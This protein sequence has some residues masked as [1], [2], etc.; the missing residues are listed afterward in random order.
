MLDLGR[1]YT[2]I[3]SFDKAEQFLQPQYFSEEFQQIS[4]EA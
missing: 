4:I 1:L 2:N 3:N